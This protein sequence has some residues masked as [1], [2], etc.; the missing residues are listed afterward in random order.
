M[1]KEEGGLFTLEA[2]VVPVYDDLPEPGVDLQRLGQQPGAA[3]P[4]PVPAYVEHLNKDKTFVWAFIKTF[5]TFSYTWIL[6]NFLLDF[7]NF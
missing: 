6:W 5:I 3:V 7:R 2:D 1:K 4:H